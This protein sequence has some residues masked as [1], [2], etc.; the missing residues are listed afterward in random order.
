M[1][2]KELGLDEAARKDLIGTAR[3][4][5]RQAI[6]DNNSDIEKIEKYWPHFKTPYA[7]GRVGDIDRLIELMREIKM[8]GV[9]DLM[10][11]EVSVV[12]IVYRPRDRYEQMFD[13]IDKMRQ[14]LGVP[15]VDSD[16]APAGKYDTKA[17]RS[18]EQKKW[19]MLKQYAE[20][21]K[22]V[23]DNPA[24]FNALTEAER[25][26]KSKNLEAL[27]NRIIDEYDEIVRKLR[28]Q[29]VEKPQ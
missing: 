1:V 2:R 13:D 5:M 7:D 14:G 21:K 28:D 15:V 27:K 8:D 6:V 25:A 10:K 12:A 19:R 23:V 17:W 26:E 20:M 16:E 3:D 29:G 18:R 11:V 22:E 9:E 4:R 24:A